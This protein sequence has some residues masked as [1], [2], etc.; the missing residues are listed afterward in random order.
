MVPQKGTGTASVLDANEWKFPYHQGA[1]C[2][3]QSKISFL[4][5]S[6]VLKDAHMKVGLLIRRL[7]EINFQCGTDWSRHLV[8]GIR[9]S[10]LEKK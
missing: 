2:S 5:L 8:S 3:E 6:W 9:R 7:V 4:M 1:I 10:S